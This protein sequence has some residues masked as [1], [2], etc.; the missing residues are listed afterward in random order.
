MQEEH[1]S[2]DKTNK[3]EDITID[4][5]SVENFFNSINTEALVKVL[6]RLED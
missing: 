3:I 4:K 1:N 6:K 2:S 5:D